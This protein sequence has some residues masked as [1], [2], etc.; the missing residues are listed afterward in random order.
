[1]ET[2]KPFLRWAGGK[3]WLVNKIHD[4]L[5]STFNDYHEPF[6]G[7]GSIFFYLKS[8]GYISQSAYLSDL[9]CNLVETYRVIRDEPRQVIE[10]LSSFENNSDF[11]YQVRKAKYDSPI[12]RSAQFIYLNRTSFNGIYRVN[13]KGEYNVPFGYRNLVMPF[14]FDN[15]L[16]TSNLLVN[17]ILERHDFMDTL[18]DVKPNDLVFLDP[19]YT[20]AH[21]NNGFV[22]Y[23]Q[24]IFAWEDQERLLSYIY[25][26]NEIGAYYIMTNAAHH[27]IENLYKKAGVQSKLTRASLI[28][29]KGA[30][31]AS[32]NEFIYTNIV[33]EKVVEVA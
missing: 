13:R 22:K 5:P 28:G 6:L 9:N 11:Y 21:E 27:S 14:D 29:G 2:V 3:T 33:D 4:Y 15:L 10:L 17:T 31:R 12:E 1:M 8:K 30:I 23:N 7:G 20:V 18:D 19:P 32:Y 25:K 26:L 16:A 24:K